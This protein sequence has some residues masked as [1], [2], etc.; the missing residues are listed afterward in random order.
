MTFEPRS[1]RLFYAVA[2]ASRFT[3]GTVSRTPILA[4]GAG[5]LLATERGVGWGNKSAVPTA[6][7]LLLA[8]RP[9]SHHHSPR[10]LVTRVQ[11]F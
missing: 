10:N 11:N 2:K 8:T 3:A 7:S 1:T 9:H 4:L 6:D 5:S